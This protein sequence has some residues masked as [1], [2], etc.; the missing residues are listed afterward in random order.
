MPTYRY[1]TRDQRTLQS[2]GAI[3][4]GIEYP[5]EVYVGKNWTCDDYV[6]PTRSKDNWFQLFEWERK[7]PVL[8]GSYVTPYVDVALA[9]RTIDGAEP[10][11]N[12]RLQWSLPNW[13]ST[14][15]YVVAAT[16]PGQP[17][18]SLPSFVG[19]LRDFPA[20]FTMFPEALMKSGRGACA[21]VGGSYVGYRFGW[22]PFLG[23]LRAMIDFVRQV[24][25][26][27]RW[28]L[29][30]ARGKKIKRRC[31]LSK[32]VKKDHGDFIS[33][34]ANGVLL[35]HRRSRV[36]RQW[37]WATTRWAF[38]PITG[39]SFFDNFHDWD[40]VLHYAWRLTYGVN[41]FGALAAVWELTPW[42]WF[43]DWFFNV[44]QLIGG[45]N[46]SLPVILESVCWMR[47]T[48]TEVTY[49]LTDRYTMPSWC[50]ISGDFMTR[51]KCKER[52]ALAH[53][54]LAQYFPALVAVPIFNGGQASIAAGLVA[55]MSNPRFK[56]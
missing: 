27:L 15:A 16:N 34:S 38:N 47:T 42:S 2:G 29:A 17:H 51:G 35:E 5:R 33:N 55:Q 12:P 28:L 24:S 8:N 11:V 50:W 36:H 32:E 31:L 40:D 46:N 26:R 41:G 22:R 6:D 45:L 18:I 21:R 9:N 13:A 7:Y 23:D 37:T 10:P 25:A 3:V 56:R 53:S 14:I 4:N 54:P 52:L 48:L 1:R 44:G 19:E 43:I 49:R 39:Y 20:L 30:L